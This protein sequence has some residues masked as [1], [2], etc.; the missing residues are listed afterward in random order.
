VQLVEHTLVHSR[1]DLLTLESEWLDEG[2]EGL[3]LRDP[4]GLYKQGRSTLREGGLI[5]LKRR[6]DGEAVVLDIEEQMHNANEA[7]EDALGH[8]KRSSK[9]AGMQ[10]M[11]VLG[12]V[13][14]RDLKTKVE[15]RIGSGFDAADRKKLWKKANRPIGR[16]VKYSYFPVG[17]KDKPRH[18]VFEGF[19]DPIDM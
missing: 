12:A 6:L 5:A 16:I 3:M 19:R 9:T 7:E 2:Y 17:V 11:G 8:T 10:P 1:K 14:V 13:F 4:Q 15:F 18:P